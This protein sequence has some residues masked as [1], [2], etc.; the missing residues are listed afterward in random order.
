[1]FPIFTSDFYSKYFSP[2]KAKINNL[3]SHFESQEK[4]KKDYCFFK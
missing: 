2:F 1:M 3:E 4:S